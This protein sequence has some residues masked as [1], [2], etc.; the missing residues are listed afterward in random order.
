MIQCPIRQ[1]CF[2]YGEASATDVILLG[3]TDLLQNGG[4][5]V[6][7]RNYL[8]CRKHC[9]MEQP[10]FLYTIVVVFL[11]SSPDVQQRF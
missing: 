8:I 10:R 4:A 6:Y 1:T 2:R 3:A 9:V 5:N 11:L 7:V